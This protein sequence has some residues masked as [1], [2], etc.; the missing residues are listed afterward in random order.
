MN[1]NLNI[2]ELRG[3]DIASRYTL[4]QENG[5]WFVPSA[6]GKSTRYKVCLKSQK[7]DCPDY[8]IRRKKCKHIFAAE[9]YFEQDFLRDLTAEEIPQVY[10][11]VPK[12]KTYKQ[13]WSA[14]NKA[15][16][17][18]KAEFQFLLSELCSGIGEPS[19]TFGRPRLPLEDMLFSCVFKVYST[20]SGRR[21]TTDLNEAQ[22]KGFI[23]KTPNHKSVC[24]YFANE[25]LTPYLKMLIEESSLPLAEIEK[26]FA[27]DASGLSTTVGFTWL[28]AKFTEPRLIDKKDW[29][30]IHICTGVKTNIISAVEVTDRF[31]ADSN[32]FETL[33]EQTVENFEMDEVSADKAYLS[34]ANLQTAVDNNAIPYIAWKSNSKVSNKAGNH[35]WNKLFHWYSLNQEKFL[36]RYHQRSNVETSFSM[37]KAKFGGTLRNKSRTAQINEALCK[38]LA[39]NICV[40]IQSMFELGIKPEFWKE[41]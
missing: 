21:F 14:Y 39:H 29:L 3:L 13:V 36:E 16:T 1:D 26:S 18:E 40:L 28:H 33:V 41:I 38:I 34:K 6:S 22:N 37:I 4:K 19:Q 7:C 12:R 23:S 27:V 24:R 25:M 5:F 2:R 8:E 31:E 20:F 30:K 15:Q 9:F 35:L 17:T 10:K 32:Y 11:P